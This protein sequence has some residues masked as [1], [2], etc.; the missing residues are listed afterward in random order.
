MWTYTDYI[1]NARVAADDAALWDSMAADAMRRADF[2]REKAAQRR[3]DAEDYREKAERTL[4]D[5]DAAPEGE[6][7]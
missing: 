5:L 2:Y 6:G 1:R 7:A 4:A 3:R